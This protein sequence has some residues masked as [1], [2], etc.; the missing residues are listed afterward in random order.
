MRWFVFD[1]IICG[2]V[3]GWVLLSGIGVA[4][5]WFQHALKHYGIREVLVT[6]RVDFHN[7]FF[8]FSVIRMR[9]EHI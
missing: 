9:N 7:I 2:V 4:V 3:G 8:P 5:V 1:F 6:C